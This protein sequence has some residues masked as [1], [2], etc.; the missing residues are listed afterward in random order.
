MAEE[1][2]FFAPY[3]FCNQFGFKRKEFVGS[4]EIF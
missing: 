4:V 2:A 3:T 1:V